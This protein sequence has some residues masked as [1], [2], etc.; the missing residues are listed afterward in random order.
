[1][2]NVMDTDG[3]KAVIKY[4]PL[5]DKF[6]GQFVGLNGGADFYAT[7]I[8]EPHKEGKLSLKVFLDLCK[9]EGIDPHKKY[10]GK[11]NLRIPPELHVEIAAKAAAEGKNLNQYVAEMLDET[12][13]QER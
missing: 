2:M 9:E 1:M 4:D 3:Y 7:N 8:E 13:H 5:I 10:S 6:R 11:F 12:I